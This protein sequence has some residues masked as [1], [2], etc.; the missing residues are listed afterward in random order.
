MGAAKNLFI[1]KHKLK[2]GGICR[3]MILTLH[4]NNLIN[5]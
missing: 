4:V 1:T 5:N 2:Q 3:S